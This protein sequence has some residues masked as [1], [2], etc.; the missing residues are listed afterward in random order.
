VAYALDVA[1]PHR[2]VADAEYLALYLAE[3]RR[4][5]ARFDPERQEA[6]H[7][8]ALLSAGRWAWAVSEDDVGAA[9]WRRH[10]APYGGLKAMTPDGMWR[11]WEPEGVG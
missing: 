2:R 8:E 11:E 7:G 4:Y 5:V 1:V 10:A 6:Q 9:R 3:V